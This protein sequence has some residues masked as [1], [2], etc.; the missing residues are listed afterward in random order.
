MDLASIIGILSGLALIA[1]A[2]TFGGES[3]I[4]V[5]VP[6]IM[7]VL[8]GTLAATLLTF[9]FKDV[10]TAFRAAFFVFTHEKPAPN[11]LIASMIRLCYISRQEGIVALSKINTQSRFL[12]KACNLISD[13]S[14]DEV[15]RMALRTE[16]DSL[17]MRHYIVQDVFRKMGTYAPAFGMLGTLIGLVQM[18]SKLDDPSTIGHAMSVALLTTFYG[19]LL[20]TLFFLPIAGKL[21]AR[22]HQQVIELEI[23]F[24][25]AISILSENNP[26]SVYEK[27]SS[28]LPA[29]DRESFDKLKGV[30]NDSK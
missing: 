12:R 14:D 5:N 3:I 15:I 24:E 6:G 26:M 4:F 2:I 29:R 30:K 21:K 1:G 27:L 7:I 10:I 20:A 28:Y 25:G 19:S 9:Q 17:K 13:G 8:G 16:I 11:D 23:M 22:T 18:L